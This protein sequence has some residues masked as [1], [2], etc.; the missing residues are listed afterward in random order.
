MVTTIL[1]GSISVSLN[2]TRGSWKQ[3]LEYRFRIESADDQNRLRAKIWPRGTLEPQGWQVE[4][5]DR[6]EQRPT[7]GRAGVAVRDGE[8]DERYFSGWQV[9]STVDG[10]QLGRRD[11]AHFDPNDGTWDTGSRLREWA[12]AEDD[13]DRPFRLLLSHNPDILLDLGAQGVGP[14][15][16]V[17]AGHTQGGQIRLPFIGALYVG[18]ELGTRYDAGLFRIDERLLYINRGMGTS[19]VPIRVLSPPELTVLSVPLDG[20]DASAG[21]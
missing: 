20:V 3:W 18:T 16:L 2:P 6:S 4:G 21:S 7:S 5:I 8:T 12:P 9:T 19:W 10:S 13:G 17:L 1:Q 15:D 14:I 11:L